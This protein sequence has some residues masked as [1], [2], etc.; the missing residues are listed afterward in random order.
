MVSVIGE[1]RA[2]LLFSPTIGAA[3]AA[4]HQIVWSLDHL[5]HRES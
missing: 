4:Q 1:P 5:S 3:V 2:P